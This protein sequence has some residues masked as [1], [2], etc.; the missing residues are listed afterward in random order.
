MPIF[1]L[2]SKDLIND[3][4]DKCGKG[5]FDMFH[6]VCYRVTDLSFRS[7]IDS[8]ISDNIIEKCYKGFHKIFL[9]NGEKIFYFH[10]HYFL[11]LIRMFFRLPYDTE[12]GDVIFNEV[13]DVIAKKKE[14][15]IDEIKARDGDEMESEEEIKKH[16]DNFTQ[17]ILRLVNNGLEEEEHIF[18][19]LLSILCAS[20]ETTT[21]STANIILCLAIHPEIQEK[22]YEE[23]VKALGDKDEVDFD[24]ISQ[25]DYLARVVKEGLRV[26]PIV[27]IV[28]RK[29]SADIKIGMLNRVCM[30]N[31]NQEHFLILNNIHSIFK[32]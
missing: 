23:V 31:M 16:Q 17:R 6:T 10:L 1:N 18:E 4:E 27:P 12:P 11:A 20:T 3:L 25:M 19:Q 29:T 15:Y 28:G 26:L 24:V 5:E 8:N 30:Y 2:V 13:K 21:T 9:M 22:L 32:L 7:N 14:E